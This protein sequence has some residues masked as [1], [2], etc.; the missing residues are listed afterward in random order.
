MSSRFMNFFRDLSGYWKKEASD[1][2]DEMWNRSLKSAVVLPAL[3][4]FC[5]GGMCICE[6]AKKRFVDKLTYT[7]Y[8][9]FL[10]DCRLLV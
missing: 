10:K 2:I 7:E 6:C 4:N 1:D 5:G 3:C 8:E 9:K